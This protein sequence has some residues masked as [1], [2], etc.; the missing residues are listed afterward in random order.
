MRIIA[1]TVL[2]VPAARPA[3]RVRELRPRRAYAAVVRYDRGWILG[4]GGN[5]EN[6]A[7]ARVVWMG[8]WVGQITYVGMLDWL[9]TS[10]DRYLFVIYNQV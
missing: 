10:P 7:A 3:C 1:G 9:T 4:A 2:R 8:G 5:A 6:R